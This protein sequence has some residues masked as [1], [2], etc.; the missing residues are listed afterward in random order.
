MMELPR[1]AKRD[2][3]CPDSY[4]LLTVIRIGHILRGFSTYVVPDKPVDQDRPGY[5]TLVEDGES[6]W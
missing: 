3:R 6:K 2:I 1:S 4:C 5:T